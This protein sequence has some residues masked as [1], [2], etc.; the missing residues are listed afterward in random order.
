MRSK[1][2]KIRITS[3]KRIYS[4]LVFL[5]TITASAQQNEVPLRIS[6]SVK[7]LVGIEVII[8]EQ[9]T[10]ILSPSGS[11][12]ISDSLGHYNFDGLN[13]GQYNLKVHGFG[14]NPLD[15]LVKLEN[16]SVVGLDL[17]IVAECGVNEE[18]AIRDIK[19][20][21]PRLLLVGSIAPVVYPD[22]H[23]F[24]KKYKVHYHDYG[25]I[26][27]ASECIVQ[28]NKRIFTYL[29]KKYGRKWRKEVRKDVIGL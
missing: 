3:P 20:G 8:P 6:G 12:A 23:L 22:Q 17:L 7:V 21:N 2:K 26:A 14:Y 9:A 4:F 16:K 5:C 13:P 10:L 18:I 27:P 28:Y 15:T 25:D 19:K 11:V 24:E 29:D 1:L